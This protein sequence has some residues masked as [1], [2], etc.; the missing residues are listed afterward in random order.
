M[1]ISFYTTNN[2]NY[3]K[4][5]ESKTYLKVIAAD[6]I[7]DTDLLSGACGLPPVPVHQEQLDSTCPSFPDL[8][9]DQHSVPTHCTALLWLKIGILSQLC[10]Y[11]S[12]WRIVRTDFPSGWYATHT[13]RDYNEETMKYRSVVIITWTSGSS[14]LLL[15]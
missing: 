6:I 14:Q 3:K 5:T 10:N 13:A 15:D 7:D 9:S 8:K 11:I 1:I 2:H 4:S 12:G